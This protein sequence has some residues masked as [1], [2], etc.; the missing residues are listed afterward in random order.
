MEE[1][2][3]KIQPKRYVIRWQ[4]NGQFLSCNIHRTLLSPARSDADDWGKKYFPRFAYH[5]AEHVWNS[6]WNKILLKWNI[7]FEIYSVWQWYTEVLSKF[8][9]CERELLFEI[10]FQSSSETYAECFKCY[11]R[12]EIINLKKGEKI[13]EKI[14]RENRY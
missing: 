4:K 13:G 1:T 2:R 9:T 3:Q 8:R 5:G 14:C 6:N 10:I 7:L 11:S 12:G